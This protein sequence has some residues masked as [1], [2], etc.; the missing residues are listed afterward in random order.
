MAFIKCSF[1]MMKKLRTSKWL[2]LKKQLKAEM[3]NLV[4]INLGERDYTIGL[5]WFSNQLV[6][7]EMLICE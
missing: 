3:F 6:S 1:Q 5:L 7:I 2:V 4:K